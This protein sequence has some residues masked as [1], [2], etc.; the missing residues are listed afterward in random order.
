MRAVLPAIHIGFAKSEIF[1]TQYARKKTVISDVDIPRARSIDQN[2][3]RLRH[4][5]YGF[6]YQEAIGSLM[7]YDGSGTPWT[8]LAKHTRDGVLIE[9]SQRGATQVLARK[10]LFSD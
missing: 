9:F 7:P 6:T 10:N 8:R 2:T 3:G 5:S 1:L 4:P